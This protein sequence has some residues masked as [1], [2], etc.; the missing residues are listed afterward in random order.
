M[1]VV[2]KN[3]DIV[4]CKIK[5]AVIV[6]SHEDYDEK[7]SFEIIS[8]NYQGWHI[9]IPHYLGIKNTTL[10]TKKNHTSLG[11]KANFID[12]EAVFI[13]SSFIVKAAL[14]LD[15]MI[16]YRCNDYF[17]FAEPNQ[18]HGLFLCWCCRN[19]RHYI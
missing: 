13:T 10:I 11:I 8:V 6:Q 7:R 17:D 3:G 2:F 18:E 5:S 1:T 9:Y 4:V 12:G 16:C 19:Y 14:I 15:G